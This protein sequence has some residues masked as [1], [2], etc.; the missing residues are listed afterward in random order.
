MGLFGKKE[1]ERNINEEDQAPSL[2]RLPELPSLPDFPDDN[3]NKEPLQQLPSYPSNATAD[4]F[5]QN[6]IKDAIEGEEEEWNA[7]GNSTEYSHEEMP[8]ASK[9]MKT[10]EIPMVKGFSKKST[11]Q[12]PK[13]FSEAARKVKEIE[14]IFIR[15]DKFEDSL[16]VF[17]DTHEKINEI[18]KMLH[19][20]K[21]LKEEEEK[22]IEYWEQELINTK[23]QIEKINDDLFSKVE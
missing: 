14:P 22:E 9:K 16:K 8:E 13:G 18:E 15:L 10:K 3:Y 23:S 5:S 21:A 11:Y 19:E 17:H 2:P 6:A 1:S 4:A 7:S 12:I 20:I